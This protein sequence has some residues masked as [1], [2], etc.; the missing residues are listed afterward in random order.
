[1]PYPSNA[2]LPLSVRAHLPEHAPEIFREA[3]NHALA[4]HGSEQSAFGVAWAAVHQ[5]VC[6][7]CGWR[8]GTESILVMAERERAPM[9]ITAPLRAAAGSCLRW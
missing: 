4:H 6:E 8:L 2:D 1:M 3:F 9:G 7:E 5:Q